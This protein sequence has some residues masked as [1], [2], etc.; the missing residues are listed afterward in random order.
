VKL[1]FSVV[2]G[3]GVGLYETVASEGLGHTG[4]NVRLKPD[5]LLRTERNEGGR[6]VAGIGAKAATGR[7][8]QIYATGAV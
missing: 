8:F 6:I 1:S 3:F 7:F 2:R 4:G 5:L